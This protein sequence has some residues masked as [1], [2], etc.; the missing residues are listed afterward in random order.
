MNPAPSLYSSRTFDK[1]RDSEVFKM[2]Y[3]EV[4]NKDNLKGRF[5]LNKGEG[6]G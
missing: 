1:V 3:T 5:L 4:L 6:A 2:S